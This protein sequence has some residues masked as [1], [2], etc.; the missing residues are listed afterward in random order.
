[1]SETPSQNRPTY[2]AAQMNEKALFL[3]LLSRLC[4]GITQPLHTFGRPPV[5]LRDI[6]FAMVFKVYSTKSCNWC[7]SDLE[8][9]KVRN[10]ISKVP[11]PNTILKYFEMKSVTVLLRQLIIES[12][13]PL[14]D[15][16]TVF[17]VDS[18]GLS[19]CR[20]AR[21]VDH[22][23]GKAEVREK[24]QWIKVHIMCG[25]L[26]NIITAVEITGPTAGDSPYFKVLLETTLKHFHVKA[27]SGDKAYSALKNLLLA[28][29]NK[30]LPFVPFK[31]NAKSV[32]RTKDPL[33][34]RLYHF[35]SLNTEW[36]E[37]HYHKRSN[38]EST[39]SMIKRKFEPN[40][41]SKTKTP[42][43][44]EA[45]CK[46]LCHNLCVIIHSMYESGIE[47]EFWRKSGENSE[48]LPS[49]KNG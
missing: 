33:W 44:N 12:S 46:I 23:Y 32:H 37:T 9:A 17:A 48:S 40:L 26:T 16:E 3:I 22:R 8:A 24:R 25:V 28:W 29:E 1:M 6:L 47:P 35:Y 45:L 14:C 15:V 39:F 7:I 34:T 38:V 42:Q 20:F 19:T 11:M 49:G 2:K 5:L 18:T 13:M 31:A 43:V 27:V 30:V 4:A 41:R 10:L 21:W 36:F